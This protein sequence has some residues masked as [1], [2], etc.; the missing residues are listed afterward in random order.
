MHG[1][2]EYEPAA[3]IYLLEK[4]LRPQP[5]VCGGAEVINGEVFLRVQQKHGSAVA[6]NK[7]IC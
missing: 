4:L 2:E 1:A 6:G 5:E 7:F 3:L